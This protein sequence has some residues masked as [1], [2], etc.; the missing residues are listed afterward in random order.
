MDKKEIDT[1]IIYAGTEIP[2]NDC[3]VKFTNKLGRKYNIEL[4]RLIQVFNNNVWENSK[5]VK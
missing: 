1:V 4:T 2:A 3:K 5:S